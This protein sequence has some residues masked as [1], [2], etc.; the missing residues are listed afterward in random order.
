MNCSTQTPRW[1]QERKVLSSNMHKLL[2][3]YEACKQAKTERVVPQDALCRKIPSFILS[4]FLVQVVQ[5]WILI[6]LYLHLHQ[7]FM[8]ISRCLYLT[9]CHGLKVVSVQKHRWEGIK[10][11]TQ[12]IDSFK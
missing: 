4:V 11:H 12:N 3:R 9:L 5:A 8:S 10:K 2:V 7:T 6:Y 1:T